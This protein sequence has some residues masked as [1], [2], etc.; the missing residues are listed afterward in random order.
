LKETPLKNPQS[1]VLGFAFSLDQK[2]VVMIKKNGLADPSHEGRFNGIGGKRY[3][4]EPIKDAMVREFREETGVTLPESLWSHRGMFYGKGYSVEV[5]TTKSDDIFK[6][7]TM[8]TEQVCI[9][10]VRLLMS[11]EQEYFE[12]CRNVPALIQ[13]CLNDG[14][15]N[16]TWADAE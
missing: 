1:Y 2:H 7:R 15:K 5:L 8:E 9:L 6:C 11:P 12:L 3:L 4:L 14:I 13:I 10:P 16:F